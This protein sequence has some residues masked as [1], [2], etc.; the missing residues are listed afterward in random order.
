MEFDINSATNLAL[1]LNV[2]RE[3]GPNNMSNEQEEFLNTLA[4]AIE[5]CNNAGTTLHINF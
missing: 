4:E 5:D 3:Y 2:L 1:L